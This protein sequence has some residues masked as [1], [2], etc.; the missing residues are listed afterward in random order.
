MRTYQDFTLSSIPAVEWPQVMTQLFADD[1]FVRMS[2]NRHNLF[3]RAENLPPKQQKA[4][5]RS[6]E[7]IDNQLRDFVWAFL[8]ERAASV[9]ALRTHDV[10]DI[11]DVIKDDPE[12]VAVYNGA[13]KQLES[14]TFLID[15]IESI[16]GDI[17]AKFRNLLP[18]ELLRIEM[19]EG[20]TTMSEQIN[21]V[22]GMTRDRLT[23][24]AQ[25]A[26][27][28]YAESIGRYMQGRMNTYIRTVKELEDGTM[29]NVPA[30]LLDTIQLMETSNEED[31]Y[32]RRIAK[33]DAI[34]ERLADMC[35][36]YHGDIK[37]M[38]LKDG[39]GEN[40]AERIASDVDAAFKDYI[41]MESPARLS[42][43]ISAIPK[44]YK[45]LK[46]RSDYFLLRMGS[47]LQKAAEDFIEVEKELGEVN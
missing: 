47:Y 45:E 41:K 16:V 20:L 38:L 44:R 35:A 39:V 11:L 7:M 30:E 1:R 12:K 34:I 3:L 5:L 29:K 37:D 6:V 40:T 19:F 14:I 9:N 32:G 28:Y 8:S 46:K 22:F 36:K 33:R 4:A 17:N 42:S 27:A 25:A 15:I 21:T 13:Y 23:P 18:G 31:S 26:F 43:M 2:N 24:R 10:S